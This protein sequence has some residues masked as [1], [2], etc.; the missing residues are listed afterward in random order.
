MARMPDPP[1]GGIIPLTSAQRE[2]LGLYCAVWSQLD[3][4]VATIIARLERVGLGVVIER[5]KNLTAGPLFKEL[6]KAAAN[7]N[8]V[9]ARL[10]IDYICDEIVFAI[11]HRNHLM[12]GM[13]VAYVDHGVERGTVCQSHKRS[14][15]I[16]AAELEKYTN[17]A[18]SFSKLLS[19]VRDEL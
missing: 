3:Y 10:N 17:E 4:L 7:S 11:E 15:L 2:E 18:S 6:R 12:H 9:A 14:L 16:H 19:I 1:P 8:N 13:W 5:T